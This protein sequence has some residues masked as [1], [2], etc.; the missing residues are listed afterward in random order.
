MK[1][2]EYE[3]DTNIKLSCDLPAYKLQVTVYHKCTEYKSNN[4]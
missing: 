3:M 4:V 2:E 1:Q